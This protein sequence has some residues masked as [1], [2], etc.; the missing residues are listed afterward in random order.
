MQGPLRHGQCKCTHVITAVI[1]CQN[2][3]SMFANLYH[4]FKN[5]K[6]IINIFQSAE[7][8][9]NFTDSCNLLAFSL[10]LGLKW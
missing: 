1:M 10:H 3:L 6:P 4:P 5:P 9:M 7:F 8:M 2:N